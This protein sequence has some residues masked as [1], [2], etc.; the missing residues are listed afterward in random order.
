MNGIELV[1]EWFRFACNDL[2]VAK[3][4]LEDLYPRQIEI[5]CFHCQ[6]AAEKAL[7]GYLLFHN[8]ESPKIHNLRLLC[9]MCMQQDNLFE[10]L[11]ASCSDLTPYGVEARYPGG[12]EA[13]EAMAKLAVL[14]DDEIYK[15]CLARIPPALEKPV[16][17]PGVP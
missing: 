1:N 7:K 6:Q 4:T 15:F 17:N 2:I 12:L 8:I 10:T 16:K 5:A 11:L 9:Q 13:D 14:K 3:H